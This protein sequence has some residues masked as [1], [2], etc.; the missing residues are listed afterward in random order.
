MYLNEMSLMEIHTAVRKPHVIVTV[1]L[2]SLL[3]LCPLVALAQG[4]GSAVALEATP[5]EAAS[6]ETASTEAASTEDNESGFFEALDIN[7]VN[8]EVF[9]TDRKGKAVE[10]LT[11]DDF[12]LRVDGRSVAI[13][14]FYAVDSGTAS[15]QV[16]ETIERRATEVETLEPIPTV[17]EEQRLY[18]IVYVD[19]LFIKPFNRNKV[20][21][22]VRSFVSEHL[23]PDDRVML[24][25]FERSLH[26]RQPFTDDIKLFN[27]QLFEIE[28]LTGY[29]VQADTERK[30]TLRNIRS[31]KTFAEAE[32]F[33]DFYAKQRF[34]DLSLSI[35]GLKKTVRSMAGLPGRKALL[36]VSDGLPMR[37]GAD[38]FLHLDQRFVDQGNGGLL[39]T[40]YSARSSFHELIAAA[41]SQRV[42]FYTLEATGLQSHGSLSAESN[43]DGGSQIEFDIERTFNNQET[44]QMLAADTG[45]LS[46]FNTNNISGALERMNA[47]FRSY[48][49]LGFVPA[50]SGDGRAHSVKVRVAK[51]GLQVRHRSS[52]RDKSA[53]TRFMESVRASLHH[54]WE[55]NPLQAD[56][57]L[58]S[59]SPY[60]GGNVIVPVT[61]SVPFSEVTLL[62]RGTE[63]SGKLRLVVAVIDEDGRT[64]IPEAESLPLTIPNA[65][66]EA[67]RKD[68]NITYTADVAVHKGP[69]YIA[70]GLRDELS[71]E[72]TVLRRGTRHQR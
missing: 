34:N 11:V 32:P 33:V 48:Y 51:K 50:H 23:G 43:S 47:D 13:S 60:E 21:R 25:T 7:V 36:Y 8:V 16:A 9:V 57:E 72:V 26:L 68:Q 53:E 12:E 30:N 67:V 63:H 65:D 27:D 14:N 5:T 29:A 28:E 41:N 31:A 40:R 22:Q 3:V 19:N 71:G 70:V 55:A 54:G 4:S 61:V 37:A 15:R 59:S 35:D 38:L 64:S 42:S 1:F 49:S 20:V 45:G 39:A 24:V 56:L 6:T 18:L 44:L 62:P 2:G 58:G 66:V 10:G 52:Y 17:N 46:A 69:H